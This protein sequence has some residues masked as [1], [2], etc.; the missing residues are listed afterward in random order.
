[1][2][3]NCRRAVLAAAGAALLISAPLHA[4][5]EVSGHTKFDTVDDER[6]EL[7]ERAVLSDSRYEPPPWIEPPAEQELKY[8]WAGNQVVTKSH[9]RNVEIK[10]TNPASP[11]KEINLTVELSD[12]FLTVK[13]NKVRVARHAGGVRN[14]I[15]RQKKTFSFFLSG[16]DDTHVVILSPMVDLQSTVRNLMICPRDIPKTVEEGTKPAL[17][18]IPTDW[19]ISQVRFSD[20]GA[21]GHARTLTGVQPGGASAAVLTST[22]VPRGV[23]YR[24]EAF[25]KDPTVSVSYTPFLEETVAEITDNRDIVGGIKVVITQHVSSGYKRVTSSWS[26]L[27]IKQV[28]VEYPIKLNVPA[29]LFFGT[30]YAKL[31]P[32]QI[33]YDVKSYAK[34]G[35]DHSGLVVDASL[36]KGNCFLFMREDHP[37]TVAYFKEPL[38]PR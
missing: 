8:I 9:L 16:Q 19:E 3:M 13:H 37:Q 18:L 20:I 35:R 11:Q 6:I 7:F 27:W 22:N 31:L 1:M 32:G 12:P 21:K 29:G 38:V 28:P 4:E 5:E 2:N 10:L 25:D 23:I 36:G 34:S 17:H 30:P 15:S 14:Q 26:S 33:V 24:D